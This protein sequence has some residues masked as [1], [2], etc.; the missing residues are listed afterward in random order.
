MK[1]L[2]MRTEK[3]TIILYCI[4]LAL[5]I[6]FIYFGIRINNQ[7]FYT[8][9]KDNIA[10]KNIQNITENNIYETA[11]KLL[12]GKNEIDSDLYKE[13]SNI[14]SS[15]FLE[16]GNFKK[17]EEF[18]EWDDNIYFFNLW[19]IYL[20]SGSQDLLSKDI[21][22]L[23]NY[24]RDIER[25]IFQYNSAIN[26]NKNSSK[27]IQSKI[28]E[29]LNI[30]KSVNKIIWYK[31]RIL[32]FEEI[33]NNINQTVENIKKLSNIF[34]T[35]KELIRKNI[36][37]PW[38]E[39]FTECFKELHKQ[40]DKNIS[41]S[42]QIQR[43]LYW[44]LS[45]ARTLYRFH[46]DNVDEDPK[47][48]FSRYDI[49][50]KAIRDVQEPIK[51]QTEIHSVILEILENNN[52]DYIQELCEK[53]KKLWEEWK[54]FEDQLSDWI[55]QLEKMLGQEKDRQQKKE[56]QK[57][58]EELEEKEK[59]DNQWSEKEEDLESDSVSNEGLHDDILN[60]EEKI[61]LEKIEKQ[62]QS[63][64]ENIQNLKSES[65]YYPY[66]HINNL[67]NEFYGKKDE[68]E[69]EKDDTMWY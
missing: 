1:I 47:E 41:N 44:Y 57:K 29:N 6:M 12:S 58:Q 14:V 33:T 56:E 50:Q 49:S 67:F 30:A 43:L 37:E 16:I 45:T 62:S 65:D 34:K 61:L 9:K 7:E 21:N 22:S 2:Q 26:L 27:K 19:N 32:I 20:L 36:K 55:N 42:L 51:K 68:F 52:P 25:S 66:G 23:R 15:K 24:Y 48:I 69:V 13:L 60:E 40:I 10:I 35:E 18:L 17:A 3:R 63:W 38:N 31:T 54:E 53:Q 8:F 28:K 5:L 46:L 64:I 4:L 11:D 39:N 59:Q